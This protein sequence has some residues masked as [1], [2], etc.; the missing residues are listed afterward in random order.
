MKTYIYPKTYS[1]FIHN[2]QKLKRTSVS[3]NWS[4]VVYSYNETVLSNNKEQ[5]VDCCDSTDQSLMHCDECKKPESKGIYCVNP[6][7]LHSGYQELKTGRVW[8][9]EGIMRCD[10]TVLYLDFGGYYAILCTSKR[11]NFTVCNF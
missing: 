5:T 11:L 8:L 1:N 2:F 6:S 10:G 3:F 9:Q 7:I 4:M